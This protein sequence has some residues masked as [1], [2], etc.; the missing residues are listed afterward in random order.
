MESAVKLY[1]LSVKESK[2]WLFSII[3]IA[4]NIILP[5]LCH[6]IPQGGLIFL[7]IYFFTLIAA[8]K[9]GITAGVLTAIIS[10]VINSLIFG[11]PLMASLPIILIK[12]TL[13]AC[14]AALIAKHTGR[15]S[16]LAIIMAVAAYQIS[17]G[18]IEW[19]MTGSF[20]AAVQDISLGLPGIALQIIGGYLCLKAIAK[21]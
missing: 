14:A 6:L 17:G 9:Y 7:P 4:G 21:L 19:A 5:Q 20:A 8:Y 3:F 2:T 1:S 10:P 16:F 15:I 18:L 12:S 13:L 11:M